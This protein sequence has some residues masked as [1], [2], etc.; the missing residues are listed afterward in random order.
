MTQFAG[1]CSI[2][3]TLKS[4]NDCLE[5]LKEKYSNIQTTTLVANNTFLIDG[6]SIID[7]TGYLADDC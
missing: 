3:R 5:E 2:Q 4:H 6:K 1:G 7:T